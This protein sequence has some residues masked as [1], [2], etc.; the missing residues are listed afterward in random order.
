MQESISPLTKLDQ[1]LSDPSGVYVNAGVDPSDYYA[2]IADDIRKHLCEPFTV[3]AVVMP[4]GFA[5]SSPGSRISGQC[6]AHRAGYWLIYQ[7]DQ[8]RFY[9]FW[10]TD[11]GNLGA[12]GVS[13]SPLYC[14]SA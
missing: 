12:H 3:S 1:A 2:S 10:G 6:V 11:P 13:G 14:W 9:C 5:G 4:P 8:D 7:P